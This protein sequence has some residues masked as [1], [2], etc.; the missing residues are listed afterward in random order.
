MSNNL[1]RATGLKGSESQNVYLK[2]TKINKFYYLW[3]TVISAKFI[4]KTKP[5]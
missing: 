3:S 2:Y 4:A 1:L 5:N